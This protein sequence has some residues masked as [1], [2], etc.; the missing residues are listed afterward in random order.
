MSERDVNAEG[1]EKSF[2]TNVMG[3][4]M[5]EVNVNTSVSIPFERHTSLSISR[6]VYPDQGTDSFTGEEC[7]AQSGEF[8]THNPLAVFLLDVI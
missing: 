5:T 1:L 8:K 2:A 3:E 6:C 4:S 7:R